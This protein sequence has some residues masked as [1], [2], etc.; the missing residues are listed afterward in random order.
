M[1]PT[2]FDFLASDSPELKPAV[3]RLSEWV[4]RHRDWNMI[5]PRRVREEIDDIDPFLLSFVLR[6]LVERGVF[7]Q[8]YRILT[9]SGV[10]A[11]GEYD[12]PNNIPLRLSNGFDEYFNR[13]D[14]VIVSILKPISK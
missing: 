4:R 5:D 7:R 12:D 8:V 13:D 1:L 9:P 10:F 2:N 11:E 3:A 14:G 6:E